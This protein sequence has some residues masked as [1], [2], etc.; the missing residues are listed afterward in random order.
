VKRGWLW[1]LTV[2]A[3]VIGA[4]AVFLFVQSR[5]GMEPLPVYGTVP[6]FVLS[7]QTGH[8]FDSEM[9][10]GDVWVA[11]FIFTRCRGQCPLMLQALQRVH[12]RSGIAV[13]GGRPRIVAFT[14]DPE[15]DTPEV[16]TGLAGDLGVEAPEWVF[17]TGARDSIYQL[18]RRGFLLGTEASGGSED[19]PILHSSRLVLVDRQGRVRGYYDGIDGEAVA[20]L[21]ADA[22]RL[23]R[24]TRP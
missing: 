8:P 22:R 3:L 16:L 10:R 13:P 23:A 1:G 17:L 20:A 14:V 15:Y 18:A 19:E 11:A 12:A 6:S 4:V 2:A 24:S 21:R 5:Y 7:D 9:L